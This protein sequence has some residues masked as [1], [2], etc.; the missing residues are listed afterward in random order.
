MPALNLAMLGNR[1]L[2]NRQPATG[3]SA[4]NPQPTTTDKPAT[5]TYRNPLDSSA[6]VAAAVGCYHSTAFEALT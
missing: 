3:N 5:G 2:G 4:T 1:Q 6:V